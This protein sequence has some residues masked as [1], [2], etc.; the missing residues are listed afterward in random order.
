MVTGDLPAKC[1]ATN[2]GIPG[3][4]STINQSRELAFVT[5]VLSAVALILWWRFLPL[6]HGDLGFYT[7]PAYLL[8]RFGT[9]AGPASQYVDL[10]YQRGFYNYPP[11]HYLLLAG[12]IKLFG[13]SPDSLLAYTHLIHTGILILLYGLIRFR[14]GCSRLI[15]SLTI[16][17]IF[18]KITHG[19]PDLPGC[20][21]SI[22]AWVALPREKNWPRT[23]LSGCLAG[24]TLLVSPGFGVGIIATLFTLMLVNRDTPFRERALK[25][26]VWGGVAGIFFTS[27]TAIVLWQQHSWVLA[28]F[29]FKTNMLHRGAQLNQM[30][31]LVMYVYLFGI[32][33]FALVAILPAIIT[34]AVNLRRPGSDLRDVTFAFLG[35]AFMWFES[36]KS[37]LLLEHH[38]LFPAKS[39][40]L[41]VLCSQKKFP[42]WLRVMPFLIISTCSFY[43]YKANFLYLGQPLRKEAA[44]AKVLPSR[45]KVVAVDSLY[46]ANAY[47]LDHTLNYE[48][49]Q[50][51]NLWPQYLAALPQHFQS[52][53]LAG[54]PKTPI[55]PNSYAVSALTR[56]TYGLPVRTDVVCVSTSDNIDSL[57]ALGRKWKLPANPFALTTCTTIQ[58]K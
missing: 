15:S 39:V 41:A 10:T 47:A 5:A 29:Q 27:I 20:L 18:P 58:P 43:L 7:E 53:F 24:A 9:L 37:Q 33:P 51:S 38:F 31:P 34:G 21:L 3:N 57:V 40:F 46:F 55:S 14:Y 12:W 2:C 36:N 30:P 49:I 42:L 50:V 56:M 35:G 54:L 52:T 8:A 25:V 19:R 44:S 32:L 17:S 45:D 1:S 16:L 13:L 26:A 23:T 28:Y 11:G 22:A 48:S 4:T 6:P